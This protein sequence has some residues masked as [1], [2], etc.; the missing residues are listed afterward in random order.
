MTVKEL[1]EHL[2]TLDQDKNIWIKYDDSMLFVP[3][4]ERIDPSFAEEEL[5]YHHDVTPEDY[6]FPTG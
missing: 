6:V 4:A 5:F 1:I 2:Q 3:Q